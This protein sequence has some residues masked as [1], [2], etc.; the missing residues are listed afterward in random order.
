M[1]LVSAAAK[2]AG[3]LSAEQREHFI[4]MIGGRHFGIDDDFQLRIHLAGFLEE[5]EGETRA[6]AESVLAII[7]AMRKRELNFLARRGLPR[8]VGKKYRTRENLARAFFIFAHHTQGERRPRLLFVAQFE[9]GDYRL[10]RE[11]LLW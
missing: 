4:K 1:Q 10:V 8:D 7:A 6:D 2:I 3:Y 11:K 9:F 5:A